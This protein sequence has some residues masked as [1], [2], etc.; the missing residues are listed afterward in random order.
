MAVPIDQLVIEIRAETAQLRKGLDKVNKKLDTTG[1]TATRLG[2][3]MKKLGAALVAL[4]VARLG[5]NVVNTIRQFEDLEATLQA[6]TGD[7]KETAAAMKM[8]T[9]FTAT[10][11]FQIDQV[12]KAFLEMRRIGIKP[13]K[14]EMAGMGK[15]AAAQN[16]SID[17]LAKGVFMA[18]TTSIETLQRMG[19]EA[20]TQGDKMVIA[21]GTG[22]DRLEKSIG[23]NVKE[24]MKFVAEVGHLKFATAL[25]DRLNTLS[26]AISNLGDQASLF[27]V[28]I[29]EAGMRDALIEFSHAL[30]EITLEQTGGGGLAEVLGVLAS[31]LTG[32]LIIA[33]K[34]LNTIARITV[35]LWNRLAQTFDFVLL[36][37]LEFAKGFPDAL[38]ELMTDFTEFINKAID[39]YNELPAMLRGE[40]LDPVDWQFSTEGLDNWIKEI[41]DRMADRDLKFL[42]GD[43]DVED[44]VSPFQQANEEYKQQMKNIAALQSRLKMGKLSLEE[45]AIAQE[46][47]NEA[48][49]S[50]NHSF[51][52]VNALWRKVLESSGPMGKAMAT[53][54]SEV[55]SLSSSFADDLVDSLMKGESALESFKNFALNIVQAVI[56][57]FMELMVIQPIVDAIL[58]AFG[59][60]MPK[61]GVGSG[62]EGAGGGALSGGQPVL[63]GERG[64]EL[65]LPSSSGTLLNNMNT[66]NAMG[67]GQN[68]VVNQSLNFST[69]VIPTVRTEITKMLPQIAE[70]TKAS[71]FDAANRGGQFGKALRGSVG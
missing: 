30:R 65:F 71:V 57:A 62:K 69:G 11:T 26:G 54:A 40:Q 12:T 24:V 10:T 67:G 48:L 55:E 58:G 34:A 44:D 16:V 42:T 7:A 37:I 61:G 52:Q 8:I 53:I 45:M 28:A 27:S 13:T 14:D 60:S 20:K 25:E 50:G 9:E 66:K 39:L 68:I 33:L 64:P 41:K 56:S 6:N 19:F 15:V 1:K 17:E 32:V 35:S 46:I 4:G 23:K 31:M 49:E 70:V 36:G 18:G 59:M 21:F 3:T 43:P 5:Q 2:G 38:N 47:L 51:E 22:T 29:G 63:V